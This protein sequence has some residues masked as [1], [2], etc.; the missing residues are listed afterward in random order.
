[1]ILYLL[2]V[3][4]TIGLAILWQNGNIIKNQ[5]IINKNIVDTYREVRNNE[6]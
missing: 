4:I 3:I 5:R 2:Y 1:M 6:K